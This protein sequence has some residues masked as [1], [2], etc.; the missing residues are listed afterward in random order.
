MN[1]M[2]TAFRCPLVIC[3]FF[4]GSGKQGLAN[5]PI[6]PL[7]GNFP[8]NASSRQGGGQR[9]GRWLDCQDSDDGHRF[10]TFADETVTLMLAL[11]LLS[12][13]TSELLLKDRQLDLRHR[14][15]DRRLE[16]GI[17]S[18]GRDAEGD[19]LAARIALGNPV[20]AE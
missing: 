14:D 16:L 11:I 17:L 6:R 13:E 1:K 5:S 2:A 9:L 20:E 10:E 3:F 15:A 4:C 8:P 7:P 12:K 18:N 19:L